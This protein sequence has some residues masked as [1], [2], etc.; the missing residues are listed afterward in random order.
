MIIDRYVIQKRDDP[1]FML[2]NYMHEM[3]GDTKPYDKKRFWTLIDNW[4]AYLTNEW[5][6]RKGHV[7]SVAL[8]KNNVN[9]S[10]FM[11]A[12]AEL[13]LQVCPS[14]LYWNPDCDVEYPTTALI[15]ASQ[16][17]T[18][19]WG[20]WDSVSE[21][22]LDASQRDYVEEH[23]P[24]EMLNIDTVDIENY[25][26]PPEIEYPDILP[27]DPYYITY[28]DG[29][30][31]DRIEFQ[32]YTH[33]E[34]WQLAHRQFK[35]FDMYD[36]LAIHTFNT[37]HCMSF[38]LYSVAAFMGAKEHYYVNW[39]DRLSMWRKGQVNILHTLY[40]RPEKKVVWFKNE[41]T[42][43]RS[44][45]GY[46]NPDKG[47]T[48][49]VAPFGVYTEKLHQLAKDHNVKISVHHGETRSKAL[50]LFT[51]PV[52]EDYVENSLGFI[53]DNFYEAVYSPQRKTMFVRAHDSDRY[54]PLSFKVDKK[55]NGEYLYAGPVETN[56][57]QK[58]VE[59]IL[60]HSEFFL[61]RKL[62]Q[63]Y[64]GLFEDATEDQMKLLNTL[65]LTEIQ[66]IDKMSFLLE[67]S[68]YRDWFMLK[69]QF[70][71]GFEEYEEGR[72]RYYYGEE[73]ANQDW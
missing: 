28:S 57:Y 44:L 9:S 49:F 60:G 35:M 37:V 51:K 39:W 61:L 43:E 4:K 26:E 1:D 27:D 5:G 32:Y 10:A 34:C 7:M 8:V 18:P 65:G 11:F 29:E 36:S 33:K 46:V 19:L 22:L 6:A 67:N 23:L 15:N 72:V 73:D 69:N 24:A 52:R 64:L 21:R 63:N 14:S 31:E 38:V 45:E 3:F 2:R 70:E 53:M 30:H 40:Q 47:Y 55:E 50:T 16:S 48:H 25:N 42:L 58:R 17:S 56:P 71:Y 62:G 54:Y 13:G 20:A 41:E 66:V 59:T 12:V 68:R